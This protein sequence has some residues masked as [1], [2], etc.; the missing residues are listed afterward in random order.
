MEAL[1]MSY[2]RDI[3]EE[4]HALKREVGHRLKTSADD[5]QQA[6]RDKAHALAD[7]IRASLT[8]FRDALAL[9]GAEIE[10]AFAGRVVTTMATALAVGV[11]IGYLLRRKP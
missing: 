11:V 10:K 2:S 1:P 6:T 4:L 3:V 5:W 7:D 9:D 8:D